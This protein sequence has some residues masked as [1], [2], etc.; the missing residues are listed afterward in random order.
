MNTNLHL[1][2]TDTGRTRNIGICGLRTSLLD[3]IVL[4]KIP[5]R[6]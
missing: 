4:L 1:A 2:R 3:I 5:K 6:K